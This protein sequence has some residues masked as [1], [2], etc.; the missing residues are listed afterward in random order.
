MDGGMGTQ[1]Q[2][3]EQH[4]GHGKV[5]LGHLLTLQSM[6]LAPHF[7][8]EIPGTCWR[9]GKVPKWLDGGALFFCHT[10]TSESCADCPWLLLAGMGWWPPLPLWPVGDTKLR[11]WRSSRAMGQ[12]CSLSWEREMQD[13]LSYA[14]SGRRWILSKASLCYYVDRQL[15][16]SLLSPSFWLGIVQ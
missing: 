14:G 6:Y 16:P 9:L 7:T 3:T 1:E 12:G 2:W 8:E 15:S 11:T 4:C 10:R 13:T 5:K